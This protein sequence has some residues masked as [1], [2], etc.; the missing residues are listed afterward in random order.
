MA[1]KRWVFLVVLFLL[2]ACGTQSYEGSQFA[3]LPLLEGSTAVQVNEVDPALRQIYLVHVETVQNPQFG[4]FSTT[5]PLIDTIE[6]YDDGMQQLGWRIVDVLE[7]GD[8]GFV[9]RYQKQSDRAIMAFSPADTSTEFLL[10]SGKVP[11]Q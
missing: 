5:M 7:F 11:N 4:Y 3:G 1:I 9:R 10:L 8:G 6:A 2:T